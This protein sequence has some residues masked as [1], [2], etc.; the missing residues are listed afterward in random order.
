MKR[1]IFRGLLASFLLWGAT[2]AWGVTACRPPAGP[3]V[4]AGDASA[5]AL[6]AGLSACAEACGAWRCL[7]CPEGTP[8]DA[9]V[10]CEETCAVAAL[11]GVPPHAACVRAATTCEAARACRGRS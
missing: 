2:L 1:D 7:G 11:V 8:N 9:G 5:C 4:D 3:V 6:P 10:S